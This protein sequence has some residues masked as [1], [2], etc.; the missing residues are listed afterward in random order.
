MFLT[1]TIC[2]GGF[3]ICFFKGDFIF[4]QK[5]EADPVNAL[6]NKSWKADSITCVGQKMKG[7]EREM[8]KTER[9]RDRDGGKNRDRIGNTTGKI[10]LVE[11]LRKL[12]GFGV[13]MWPCAYRHWLST[14]VMITFT[15]FQ[16]FP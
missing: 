15:S 14:N 3:S 10:G 1:D 6:G 11:R 9:K 16:F 7:K 2:F 13:F 4:V 5:A 8:K 12:D